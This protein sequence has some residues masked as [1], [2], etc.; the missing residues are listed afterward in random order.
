LQDGS[1]QQKY[2]ATVSRV[3]VDVIVTDDDGHFI[4]D[5]EEDDFTVYEDG[6]PKDILELQLV[7]LSG[8]ARQIDGRS[9]ATLAPDREVVLPS[10]P[11]GSAPST[12]DHSLTNYGALVFV[13]DGLNI[14]RRSRSRFASEWAAYQMK[15]GS[16]AVRR[17]AYL[18]DELGRLHELAPLGREPEA[19]LRAAEH[20]S[21]GRII[22]ES[23]NRVFATLYG[24]TGPPFDAVTRA[25]RT[26]DA[27]AAVCDALATLPGR[28]ALVWISD[29]LSV[30]SISSSGQR[31]PFVVPNLDRRITRR[32]RSFHQAANTAGV[33]VYSID[34][35]LLTWRGIG[36]SASSNRGPVDRIIAEAT[37]S[38]ALGWD[39]EKD[40]LVQTARATGGKAFLYARNIEK[41]LRTIDEDASRYYLLTYATP[42]PVGDGLYHEIRV[43]VRDPDLEVRARAGYLD[44]SAEARHQ[45]ALEAHMRFSLSLSELVVLAKAY[46]RWDPMGRSVV[47][48]AAT[49][50]DVEGRPEKGWAWFHAVA[51]DADGYAVDQAHVEVGVAH[52]IEGAAL[53]LP[54]GWPFVHVHDLSMRPGNYEITVALAEEAEG[55]VGATELRVAVPEGEDWQTSDLILAVRPGP[56]SPLSRP[57]LDDRVRLGE[58]VVTYVEVRGGLQ[59]VLDGRWRGPGKSDGALAPSPVSLV[60]DRVGIHR[61]ALQWRPERAGAYVIQ[62]AV[63]DS[64]AGE[65]RMLE[66]E[67]EVVAR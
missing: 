31:S 35:A 55:R 10:R 63:L 21:G 36:G 24:S 42:E 16:S 50:T 19:M 5:L 62:V 53:P 44:L 11:K 14:G 37:G 39:D 59:P 51:F 61:G 34:P 52:P 22:S 18:I 48:L 17:A 32:Q 29:G 65:R 1:A 23:A 47:Q 9:G 57:L 27:L 30:V 40:S 13:I 15:T 45:R 33:S 66:A 58:I 7:T 46:R 20:V 8:V 64:E 28:K 38:G 4:G 3:R 54:D 12:A 60:A 49:A 6:E 56:E 2:N 41:A 25:A 67:I 26:Y 43:E